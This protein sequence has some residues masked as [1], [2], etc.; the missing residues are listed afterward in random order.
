LID[1]KK[2]E[3]DFDLVLLTI[4]AR[5]ARDINIPGRENM[6]I[7]QAL[8]YL[9]LQ[10]RALAGEAGGIEPV[11]AYG[12][13]VLVIG[14]GDTGSD[15]VGTA[16]RQGALRVTQIE[17]LPK[18]PQH[19]PREEPWPLWPKVLKTSSS[20]LEG[21]ER[22]WSVNTKSFIGRNGKAEAVHACKV[23]WTR[24]NGKWNMNE[25]PGS[26]FEIGSD[27]V[28]LAMGFTHVVQEGIVKDFGLDLDERGNI[29]TKGSFHTSNPKVWAAGDSRFGASLVVRAVADGRA[30][31]EAI[32]R[33]L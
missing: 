27:L 16:N 20:H 15:C 5:S 10:N 2:L 24:V 11:T 19:R 22:L 9:S 21:S 3:A 13:R 18:P 12:K 29:R 33:A 25:I 32:V 26:D 7:V 6:G 23:E 30:A 14:G 31:A 8:D 17:V 4:G 28:L 1:P